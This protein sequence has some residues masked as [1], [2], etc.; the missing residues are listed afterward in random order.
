M[1]KRAFTLIELLLAV[2]LTG[3]V[4][5]V[6]VATYAF[7]VTRLAQTTARFTSTDQVRKVLDEV[8]D[9]VRDS[10]SVTVVSTAQNPGLKCILA[11]DSKKAAD[12]AAS[13]LLAS[14]R[15]ANPIAVSKRGFE[16][17]GSGKRVWFYMG[18]A[19]GNFGTAGSY[20]WRA[21]RNDDSNPTAADRVLGWSNYYASGG[22]RF[23][24]LAG[25]TFSLD[26]VNRNV[27]MTAIGRSLWRDERT[28]TGSDGDS[29][30][31]TESRTVSWRHWFK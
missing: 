16:R 6:T 8:E 31:F 14:D 19:S 10:V 3:M 2:A 21:E 15:L 7:T 25:F 13:R 24:V 4:L 1:A 9:V 26:A 18:D 23:P 17:H 11:A 22:S 27:S 28:G 20:L 30:T 5:G 12:A 29:Q